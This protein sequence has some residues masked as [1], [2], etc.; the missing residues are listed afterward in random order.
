MKP[1]SAGS[2]R[3]RK[4]APRRKKAPAKKQK[5]LEPSA[6]ARAIRAG[7]RPPP[8]TSSGLSMFTVLLL[9]V[10][11]GISYLMVM[12][13]VPRDLSSIKG[14]PSD[15]DDEKPVRNLLPES[16]DTLTQRDNRMVISEEDMNRYL[17]KR[18]AGKQEG[19]MGSF[20]KFEG[21]Y[22]DF[23]KG[24]VDAYVV[25][26]VFGL[27]FSISCKVTKGEKFKGGYN[28]ELGR[29]GSIGSLNVPGRQLQ[30][31]IK[32]FST[33]SVICKDELQIMN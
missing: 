32:V 14:Y 11:V 33:L 28:W 9:I 18:V 13:V 31:I 2:P 24:Y 3:R 25:R 7:H 4:S 19:A 12:V 10:A 23:K 17:R 16:L 30:P 20:M 5:P 26:S 29:G 8:A 27:P 21:V 6:A 1:Q 15:A 22:V